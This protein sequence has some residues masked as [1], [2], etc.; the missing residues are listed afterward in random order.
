MTTSIEIWGKPVCP[1]CIKA[2]HLCERLNIDYEYKELGKDFDREVIMEQFPGA[3][4][5]P[6]IKVNGKAIGGYEQLTQYI[7]DHNFNGTG[8]S[9]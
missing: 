7:E 2:K 3:R 9:L 4:T 6:Q 1:Y 5:F 8:H